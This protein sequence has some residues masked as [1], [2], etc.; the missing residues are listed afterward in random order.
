M[1]EMIWNVSPWDPVSFVAVAAV[2]MVV[3]LQ[4][5]LWPALRATRVNPVSALRKE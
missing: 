3:G 5:T 2:L 4:A 1:R